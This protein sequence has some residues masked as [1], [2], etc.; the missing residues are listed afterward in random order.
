MEILG[1][2]TAA[3][4]ADELLYTVDVDQLMHI[5]GDGRHAHARALHGNGRALVASRI[6]E[7]IA[8]MRVFFSVREKVFSDVLRTQGIAR[9]QNALGNIAD[10]SGVVWCWHDGL[11]LGM[12]FIRIL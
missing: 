11:L 4:D 6:A 7:H 10:F 5:D 2:R 3:A 12:V 1:E 9:Q 8:H